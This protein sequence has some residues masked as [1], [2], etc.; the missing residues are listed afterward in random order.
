MYIRSAVAHALYRVRLALRRLAWPSRVA[1]HAVTRC[2]AASGHWLD[3][4]APNSVSDENCGGGDGARAMNP[5]CRHL[6]QYRT[7]CPGPCRYYGTDLRD[8]LG[9]PGPNGRH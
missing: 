8:P 4:M 3:L 2:G 1:R 6:M 7:P 9:P 5:T